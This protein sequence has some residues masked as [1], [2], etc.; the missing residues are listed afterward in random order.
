MDQAVS[1]QGLTATTV[2]KEREIITE[3]IKFKKHQKNYWL[4]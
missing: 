3:F 4:N 1:S 2:E